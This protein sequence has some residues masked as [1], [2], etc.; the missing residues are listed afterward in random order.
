MKKVKVIIGMMVISILTFSVFAY[1]TE[2]FPLC[3]DPACQGQSVL[4]ENIVVWRDYRNDDGDIYGYDLVNSSEFFIPASPGY[5]WHPAIYKN[6]VVWEYWTNNDNSLPAYLH[7]ED[8]DDIELYSDIY[9]YDLETNT[10]FPV[11]TVSGDQYNPAIYENIVVW[12]DERNE[13]CDI[14]GYDLKTKTEFPICIDLNNRYDQYYPAIYGNIVVW[15]DERNGNWDIYGYDLITKRE[16]PI[17]TAS[18]DQWTPAIYRN[19]VVWTDDR[20]GNWDIYGYDLETQTEFPICTDPDTQWDP[21]IYGNTVI[22]H[23]WKDIYGTTLEKTLVKETFD[24]L[25]LLRLIMMRVESLLLSI[26]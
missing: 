22:W 8:I 19:I 2:R 6:V 16:F 14:Y 1:G 13:D 23:D 24:T 5:Q 12:Q 20:N 4:Y 25:V 11:C 9:G 7:P 15:Q 18:G 10:E 21:K 17:C 26:L 3:T